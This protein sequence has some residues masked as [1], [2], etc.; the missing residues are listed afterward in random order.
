M[1]RGAEPKVL[2][3]DIEIAPAVTLSF[4]FFKA[5]PYRI[6]RGKQII[7]ICWKWY[8]QNTI[9]GYNVSDFPS[10]KPGKT[11]LHGIEL[12]N[13]KELIEKFL[14]AFDQA[15]AVIG[16]NMKGFDIKYLRQRAAYHKMRPT[17]EPYIIDTLR[18]VRKM[19]NLE[20]NRL[21]YA[22]EYFGIGT[23]TKRRYDDIIDGFLMGDEKDQLDMKKY[24]KQDV[25]I[26]DKLYAKIAPW[27][28]K[29]INLNQFRRRGVT[30][31]KVCGAYG[32]RLMKKGFDKS[33]RRWWRQKYRCKDCGHLFRGEKVN[34]D[35][36]EYHEMSL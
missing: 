8:G 11:L 19:F 5:N 18:E 27:M 34:K 9:Y 29:H 6:V 25:N 32:E 22:C 31:C 10:Y 30:S 20:S 26:N 2:V 7:T 33:P 4:N 12:L 17:N 24:C 35:V 16:H 23:K 21:D 36:E 15:D 1:L 28:V 14:E 13:D 3:W